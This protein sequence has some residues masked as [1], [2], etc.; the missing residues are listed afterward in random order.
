MKITLMM[1]GLCIT[2][3]SSILMVYCINDN[4]LYY[5]GITS[6]IVYIIS[7]IYATTNHNDSNKV[8]LNIE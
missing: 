7:I 1:I 5:I 6:L 2:I 4:K 3:I 8:I